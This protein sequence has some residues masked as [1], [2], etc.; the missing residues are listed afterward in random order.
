MTF[1]PVTDDEWPAVRIRPRKGVSSLPWSGL[2]CIVLPGAGGFLDFQVSVMFLH[3][4]ENPGG[5]WTAR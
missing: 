2:V 4:A 5:L 1:V 3:L